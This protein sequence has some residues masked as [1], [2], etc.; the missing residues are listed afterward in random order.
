MGPVVIADL[1]P[2]RLCFA[3]LRGGVARLDRVEVRLTQA[4]DLGAGPVDRI[5]YVPGE[6]AAVMYPRESWR[7][8]TADEVRAA[9]ALLEKL[10]KEARDA[11]A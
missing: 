9:R 8:M 1:L 2:T 7:D 5:D 3:V 6:I 11:A 10:T 4:P